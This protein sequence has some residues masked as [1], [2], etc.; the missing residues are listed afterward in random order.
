MC[1]NMACFYF[2]FLFF[3]FIFSTVLLS[4]DMMRAQPYI[5]YTLLRL[6]NDVGHLRV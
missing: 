5:P 4:S 3:I 2:Y 1:E 6:F